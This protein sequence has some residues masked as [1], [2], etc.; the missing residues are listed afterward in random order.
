MRSHVTIYCDGACSPNP[1][2]GGWGAVLIS[3]SHGARRE[4][5]GAEAN[6]TN[7]RMELT[8]A[9]QALAVLKHPCIVDLFTD[10][11]YVQNAFTE[12]WIDKW[13]KNGWRNSG[14]KPVSNEDLWR[15]LVELS[16]VHHIRWHW[17][18]GHADS[19]ENNRADQLAVEARVHLA[20]RLEEGPG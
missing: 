18:R 9:I 1:G 2:V 4:I 13:M 19:N 17:V 20:S 3:E 7:N 6:T 11:Q 5:S 12:G 15:R 8:G 14:K 16:A 10:S